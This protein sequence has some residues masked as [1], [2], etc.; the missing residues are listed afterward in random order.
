M[1]FVIMLFM[2]LFIGVC[3][4]ILALGASRAFGGKEKEKPIGAKTTQ[5]RVG[6]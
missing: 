3:A 4:V 5:A 1:F 2:T 6:S